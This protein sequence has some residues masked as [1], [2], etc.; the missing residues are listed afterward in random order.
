M[1][2][3]RGKPKVAKL[4]PKQRVMMGFSSNVK[5][6]L[7]AFVGNL[8]DQAFRPAAYA[9]VT[10]LY[11][12]MRFRTEGGQGDGTLRDSIYRWRVK[13]D[14]GNQAIFYA[15]V[16]KR[17]APHWWLVENGHWQYYTVIRPADGP[18]AGQYVTLK[19]K[20][21][22]VPKWVPAK[23]Y[24]RP[25]ADK[26]PQAMQVAMRVLKERTKY[27]IRGVNAPPIDAEYE[28]Y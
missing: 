23:P 27:L 13:E 16:N 14:I 11:Y 8:K 26:L 15:G 2:R 1:N 22:P 12:E 24:I 9:A 17:K 19:N 25:A 3:G 6:Q 18:Y 4:Y 28:F 21:L 7:E 5:E 10:L 20:P